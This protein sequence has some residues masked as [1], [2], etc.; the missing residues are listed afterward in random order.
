VA[1]RISGPPEGG[2]NLLRMPAG[3][4]ASEWTG[5][6]HL[7]DREATRCPPP[8]LLGSAQGQTQSGAQ[9]PQLRPEAVVASGVKEP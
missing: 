2:G 1:A 8:A 9:A 5:R 6:D 4:R 7:L 3:P